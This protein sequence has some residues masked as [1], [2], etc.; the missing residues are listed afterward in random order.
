MLHLSTILKHYKRRDVQEAMILAAQ[1]REVAVRFGEKGFGKRPDI[2]AYPNDILELAKNGATSFHVSEERWHN[3]MNLNTG[4]KKEEIDNLR[5][6]WDLVID[7]D[8]KLWDY[9]RRIAHLVVQELHSHGIKS[10]TA[11]FSG[12]KGFHI[13]VPFEAFPKEVQGQPIQLLFPD[14][15]RRIAQ[16][17]AE[18]IKPQLL[19]YINQNDSFTRVS[20]E[21][22]IKEQ[23]L[24]KKICL[25]CKKEMK[26]EAAKVEFYCTYCD[27]KE[28]S[29][30]EK[31]KLCPECKKIMEKIE[32]PS[33]E[34][35]PYCKAT[36]FT[37]ELDIE[38]LLQIDTV[39]ISS[40][41]LYRMPYSLH[42]KSGLCSTPLD[43]DKILTFE[44][45]AAKPEFVQVAIPFL[46]A[47]NI[48]SGEATRFILQAFDFNP[49]QEEEETPKKVFNEEIL[50]TAIPAEFFPPC[51]KCGLQGM[52]DG[53]KRFMFAAVNFLLSCGYDY[54]ALEVIL[55]EWNK[56][57][58]EPLREVILKG[59][60][61][62]AEQT[63]KK[64]LPPNCDNKGYYADMQICK[65]DGLCGR[66]KNPVQ[67][68]KRRAFIANM[69][70]E[71][72]EKPEHIRK[73][74]TDEQKAMRKAFR[75][76]MNQ[77]K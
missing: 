22:G 66:I 36:K 43:P 70:K 56:K 32:M 64:I 54:A 52:K 47:E 39:L 5:K 45:D 50:S 27:K 7:I 42:E 48:T 38:P 76:K 12:N 25:E 62:Y 10:V 2:L 15:V 6:G 58:P 1:D 65:P 11:K 49:V 41:H 24:Y 67:Y 8:C 21:L 71:N 77:K 34:R 74:L 28:P 57:N 16:Y 55:D 44:R 13:A 9:S 69:Q 33:V 30:N 3:V 73:K 61:R 26:T 18:K 23:E 68:A 75:D 72:T 59:Q 63:R 14:G 37:E 17:L 4:M 46:T 29:D 60:L 40:R 51:M 20:A 31:F 19:Q 35:C 53:K